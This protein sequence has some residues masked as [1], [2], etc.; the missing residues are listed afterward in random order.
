MDIFNLIKLEKTA[1]REMKDGKKGK[2]LAGSLVKPGI[3]FCIGTIFEI[4]AAEI[5][6]PIL[7]DVVE[8][9]INGG[10]R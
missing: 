8:E 9:W 3:L 4:A 10:S 5:L 1:Y 7:A 2:E 6:G